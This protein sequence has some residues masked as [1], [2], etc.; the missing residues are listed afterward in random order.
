MN[1]NCSC[2]TDGWVV[3]PVRFNIIKFDLSSKTMAPTAII[4]DPSAQYGLQNLEDMATQNADIN[5]A[6]GV[7]G[8]YFWELDSSVRSSYLICQYEAHDDADDDSL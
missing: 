1:Q 3:G 2:T 6:V 5:L 7:N 8:G 4:A